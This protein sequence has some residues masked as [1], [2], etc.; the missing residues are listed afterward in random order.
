MEKYVTSLKELIAQS[1]TE[2]YEINE[3]AMKNE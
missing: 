3:G 1:S 2:S